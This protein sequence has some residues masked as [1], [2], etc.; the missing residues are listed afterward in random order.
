[1]GGG[2]GAHFNIIFFVKLGRIIPFSIKYKQVYTTQINWV[3]STCLEGKP[4][5]LATGPHYKPSKNN[6]VLVFPARLDMSLIHD[7]TLH[8]YINW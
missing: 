8:N 2:G 3:A 1:M 4:S 6:T 5:L 7:Q